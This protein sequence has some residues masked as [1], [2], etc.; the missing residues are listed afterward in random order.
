[1]NTPQEKTTTD[2]DGERLQTND[3]CCPNGNG[4]HDQT[5]AHCGCRC[6]T[7]NEQTTHAFEEQTIKV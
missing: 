1:M 4:R 6:A 2:A 3:S 7:K 5:C